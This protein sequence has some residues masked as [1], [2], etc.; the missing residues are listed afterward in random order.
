M[1]NYMKNSIIQKIIDDEIEA[2]FICK[3]SDVNIAIDTDIYV[4]SYLII[5]SI[6]Q[7]AGRLV[8]EY[9]QKQYGGYIVQIK[10][11]SFSKPI[12]CNTLIT[13]KAKYISYNKKNECSF[14]SISVTQGNILLV[15]G[16]TLIIKQD[17]SI[18]EEFLNNSIF[19]TKG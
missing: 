13:I 7:T 2:L 5:E 17:S 4:P 19:L 18:K 1:F 10:G 3:Q 12:Y 11:L 8:R 14:V 16:A 15:N 9:K 6:F